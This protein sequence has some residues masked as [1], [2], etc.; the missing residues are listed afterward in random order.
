MIF[1][2]VMT[3]LW[4]SQW[5]YGQTPSIVNV[6]FDLQDST[7]LIQYDLLIAEK[8]KSGNTE[9]ALDGEYRTELFLKKESDSEFMYRPEK[10]SGDVGIVTTTGKD[11]TIVWNILDELPGGVDDT[12]FYF[13]VA[14]VPAEPAGSS[15]YLWYGAGAALV[16]T[17]IVTYFI[18]SEEKEKDAAPGKFP[19]P[20]GRPK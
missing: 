12:D 1:M 15:Q 10:I 8:K 18:A 7:V 14:L 3:F 2:I 19:L 6:R 20:P 17:G 11:K 4:V 9:Y 13:E 16:A 5:S